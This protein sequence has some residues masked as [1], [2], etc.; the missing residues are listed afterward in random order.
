MNLFFDTSVLLD[1]ALR[2]APHFARSDAV[3]KDAIENHTC[4]MSWHT[5]SNISY[6][7]EKLEGREAA[8]A[9]IRNVS[10]VCRIAPVGHSDLGVAFCHDGGDFEDAMQIA[11]ALA[12][13]AEMIVTRDPSGFTKSPIP[14][15]AP[16]SWQS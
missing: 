12:C 5:V 15:T 6:I 11:S 14:L 10:S 7:V 16:Q 4:F 2:R 8:L 13:Q 1:V 3:L 9:F